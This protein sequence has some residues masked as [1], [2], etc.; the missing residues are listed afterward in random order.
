[1]DEAAHLE[2]PDAIEASLDQ[3]TRVRIDISSVAGVG[4]VFHRKREAAT[5]W[6]PGDEMEQFKTYCF[7]MDWRD[8]PLKSQEWYDT[9]K[10]ERAEQGLSHVFAQEVDRDYSAAVE[11]TILQRDWIEAA[12]DAHKKIPGMTIGK[13]VAGLD[14]A[15]GGGDRNALARRKGS[16]L[17]HLEQ[18]GERDTGAT[19]RRCVAAVAKFLPVDVMYDCV[20]VGSGVK[21]EINRLRGEKLLPSGVKFHPWDA[22]ASPSDPDGLVIPGD[23]SSPLNKDFYANLKGQGW[24]S[25]RRRFECTPGSTAWRFGPLRPAAHMRRTSILASLAASPPGFLIPA[26]GGER[27]PDIGL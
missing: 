14:V 26:L 17:E 15:D 18:W 24:W 23:Q 2:H 12:I 16:V 9:R 22:G 21:A 4:N 6:E 11:N 8:N 25:L 1:V 10:A 3:N 5:D 13:Y 19:A 20:G 7:V 27:L